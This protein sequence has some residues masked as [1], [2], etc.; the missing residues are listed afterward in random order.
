M[1]ADLSAAS[2]S[3]TTGGKSVTVVE[4]PVVNGYGENTLV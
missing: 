2:V 3:M 1:A 4:H